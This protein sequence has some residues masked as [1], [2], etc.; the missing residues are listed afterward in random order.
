[1]QVTPVGPEYL[2]L[3]QKVH[4]LSILEDLHLLKLFSFDAEFPIR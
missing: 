3:V 1:M 4:I 2:Y